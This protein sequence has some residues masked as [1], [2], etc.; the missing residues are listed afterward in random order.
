MDIKYEQIWV[1]TVG[2]TFLSSL[3]VIRTEDILLT[4]TLA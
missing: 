3:S 4:V 1:G 2:G